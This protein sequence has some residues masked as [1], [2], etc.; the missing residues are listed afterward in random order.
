[1][2]EEIMDRV[3][4]VSML[5]LRSEV[6]LFMIDCAVKWS[7]SQDTIKKIKEE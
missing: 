6:F 1:M 4:K 5:R 2:F 3:M 7:V